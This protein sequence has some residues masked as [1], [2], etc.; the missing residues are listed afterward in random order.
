MRIFLTL[1]FSVMLSLKLFAYSYAAAGVEPTIQSREAIL[2]AINAGDY[3]KAMQIYNEESQNYKYLST[4]NKNLS[5]GLRDAI[6]K[7]D[8]KSIARWLN[9]SLACEIERRVEGALENIDDF[10]V[11]KV[12]LAKVDRF[13]RILSPSLDKSIDLKLKTAIKGC[14]SSIANPGL[15]GVGA[16][17]ADI[18][19]YKRYQKDILDS[20]KNL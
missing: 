10:N 15:F 11:T 19:E 12:M 6:E 2:G 20:L 16:K 7:K 14:A 5:N 18:L 3:T 13:Y 4:F 8:N 9:I 17:G 1:F